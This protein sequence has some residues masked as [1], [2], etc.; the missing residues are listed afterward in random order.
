MRIRSVG[1]PAPAGEFSGAQTKV[2]RAIGMWKGLGKDSPSKAMVAMIAGYSHSSGGFG[3]LLGQLRSA[4]AIE[5][6]VPGAV[7]LLADVAAMPP[8]E[9]KAAFLEKLTGPQHK[10]V[11]VL[12]HAGEMSKKSLGEATG[13][14]PTSGGF[15][16]I[17][18]QLRTLG[19][20]DYP[21]PGQVAMES[22][23][24]EIL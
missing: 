20:I 7:R 19:V 3:N 24:F 18:G 23:V 21:R 17:L 9:A 10:V 4:G 1:A 6:P 15:G 13:Y 22:W 12:E 16:N 8:S 14:S 11:D 5:Y 2:L